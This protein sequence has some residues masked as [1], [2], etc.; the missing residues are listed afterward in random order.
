MKAYYCDRCGKLMDDC[1]G[2]AFQDTLWIE[3]NDNKDAYKY[4]ELCGE[5][6]KE[7]QSFPK[8]LLKKEKIYIMSQI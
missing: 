1:Y 8:F 5:C 6:Y 2:V 3:T 4:L 7:L